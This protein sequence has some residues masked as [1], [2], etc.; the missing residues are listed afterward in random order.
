VGGSVYVPGS[1]Q[2]AWWA[3][4]C[5]MACVVCLSH[6][7]CMHFVVAASPPPPPPFL[8]QEGGMCAQHVCTYSQR[9]G[10]YHRH[11]FIHPLHLSATG[12]GPPHALRD[13]LQAGAQPCAALVL[14]LG[15]GCS[16]WF[17][18]GGSG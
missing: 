13:W 16:R 17:L 6:G 1:C 14:V 15:Q 4:F 3:P 9:G 8:T 11:V 10:G 18:S 5:S 7:H 2:Q 12:V